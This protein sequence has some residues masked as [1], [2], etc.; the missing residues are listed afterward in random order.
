M[1]AGIFVTS[2]GAENQLRLVMK[3]VVKGIEAQTTAF[4]LEKTVF[5]VPKG[6]LIFVGIIICD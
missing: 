4:E 2:V 1:L 5:N 3:G 6:D